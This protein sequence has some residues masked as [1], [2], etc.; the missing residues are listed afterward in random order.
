M[1][2]TILGCGSAGG[3]PLIGGEWGACDPSNPRNRRLRPSVLVEEGREALLFDT[4]PDLRQ[5]LLN[6]NLKNLSALFYTHAHADHCHGIDDLRSVNW[7]MGRSLPTYADR[8][9]LEE[10]KTRF[11]YAFNPPVT[12][13][14]YFVPSLEPYVIEG[15]LTFGSLKVTAFQLDHGRRHVLGFRVNDFAYTTDASD[16]SEDVFNLLSGVKVWVVG[17]IR[18]RAHP[19]HAHLEKVLT[20]IERVK[21]EQ[22]VLTHMDHRLDYAAMV[23]KLPP[24][25]QPA[26]DGLV[27]TC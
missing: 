16:L 3:V 17:C 7:L 1:K 11:G 26:F 13:G 27:L 2:I 15:P 12:P 8:L 23:A 5:Q 9:T 25:T 10:L 18:E 22:A 14:K 21:P 24:G 20:W 4:S 6:C 19:S